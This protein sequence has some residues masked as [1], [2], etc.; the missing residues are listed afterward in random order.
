MMKSILRDQK[1][2]TGLALDKSKECLVRPNTLLAKDLCQE[3]YNDDKDGKN[4]AKS[5]IM[6]IKMAKIQRHHQK[7][8]KIQKSCLNVRS[9]IR[10]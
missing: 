1:F 10:Q 5:H 8:M 7:L 9:G 2:S 3:S 6:M 4:T